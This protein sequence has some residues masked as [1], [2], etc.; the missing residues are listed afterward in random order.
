MEGV[1]YGVN[2]IKIGERMCV[3]KKNA[4]RVA[5]SVAG[6]RKQKKQCV[7]ENVAWRAGA[8]KKKTRDKA[9]NQ[10]RKIINLKSKIN[11]KF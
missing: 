9:L 5:K 3:T 11:T 8:K 6:W 10:K 2:G 7:A 1:F 4:V